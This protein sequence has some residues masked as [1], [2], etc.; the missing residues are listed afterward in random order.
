MLDDGDIVSTPL[1][2]DQTDQL[3]VKLRDESHRFANR[4]RK[5]RYSKEMKK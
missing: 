4:Y 2:Y 5:K 1:I 3:L